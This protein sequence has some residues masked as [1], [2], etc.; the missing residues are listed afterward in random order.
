M[1]LR[2]DI[3]PQE[4]HV[5]RVFAVMEDKAAPL[6]DAAVLDSLGADG[7]LHSEEIELFDLEDLQDMPL[8]TYL[9][10]GHGIQERQLREMRGQLDGLTGRVL[11]LPSRAFGGRAMKMRV[12]AGLR[13]VARLEEDVPAV[14]FD[15]LPAGGAHGTVAGTGEPAEAPPGMRRAALA[16]VVLLLAGLGL[17]AFLMGRS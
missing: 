15:P 7:D 14:S 12:G 2:L 1:S 4:A 8:S 11:I 3:P 16:L 13:L 17:A 9:A 5:V 10:E 6:Q